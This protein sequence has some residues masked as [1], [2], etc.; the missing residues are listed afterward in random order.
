V[1]TVPRTPTKCHHRWTP[2]SERA[3]RDVDLVTSA[4]CLERARFMLETR[5]ARNDMRLLIGRP[6]LRSNR[7]QRRVPT[8]RRNLTLDRLLEH[9]PSGR[10]V[11][12]Q[13]LRIARVIHYEATHGDR[14]NIRR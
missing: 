6:G 11:N 5:S 7:K 4:P 9:R 13:F 14:P 12:L 1:S 10:G 8:G 2:Q 3:R